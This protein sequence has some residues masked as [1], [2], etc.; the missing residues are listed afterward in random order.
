MQVVR[1]SFSGHKL[2]DLRKH[3]GISRTVLA[4]VVGRTADSIGNCERGMTTPSGEVI[5][6]LAEHLDWSP[7]D[8]FECESVDA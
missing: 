6:A 8:F 1:R 3:A 2:R 7:D 5:A 4:F